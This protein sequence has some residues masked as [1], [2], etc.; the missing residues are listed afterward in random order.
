LHRDE[1]T[2]EQLAAAA[3]LPSVIAQREGKWLCI[4]GPSDLDECHKDPEELMRRL[5]A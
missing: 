2:P 1:A 4:L 3:S 5:L